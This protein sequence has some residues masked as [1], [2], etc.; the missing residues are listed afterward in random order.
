M[1]IKLT[2]IFLLFFYNFAFAKTKFEKRFEK[3]LNN[4][5]Y[6]DITKSNCEAKLIFGKHHGIPL[7]KCFAEKQSNVN[8]VINFLEQIY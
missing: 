7:T 4:V 6:K 1:K 8:D 3:D 5:M 2:L